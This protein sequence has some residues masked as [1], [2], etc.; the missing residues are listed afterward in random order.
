MPIKIFFANRTQEQIAQ[1]GLANIHKRLLDD[2][3]AGE[4]AFLIDG[5]EYFVRFR[6]VQ[7][8]PFPEHP[9]MFQVKLT[10]EWAIGNYMQAEIDEIVHGELLRPDY[11]GTNEKGEA[12]QGHEATRAGRV[13]HPTAAGWRRV[14]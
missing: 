7:P 13:F 3:L 9:G 14:Q 1:E 8:Q 12:I 5:R 6:K 10:V 2:A 4:M 11:K